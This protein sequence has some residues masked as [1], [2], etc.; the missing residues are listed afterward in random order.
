MSAVDVKINFSLSKGSVMALNLSQTSGIFWWESHTKSVHLVL[1]H[2]F[3]ISNFFWDL[4][5]YKNIRWIK[6]VQEKSI[7]IEA[8]AIY[9]HLTY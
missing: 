9:G 3:S 8:S 1:Y 7:F 6:Q 4:L 5:T 2:F